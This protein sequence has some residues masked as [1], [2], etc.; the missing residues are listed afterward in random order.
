MLD[1]DMTI[2]EIKKELEG[3]GDFVQIDELTR[4]L[5]QKIKPDVRKFL[6]ERLAVIYEAKGM[7]VDAARMHNN[8]A[9]ASIAFAEKKIHHIAEAELYIDAGQFD[10]ADQAMKKAMSDASPSEKAEIFVTIKNYY[11][12]HAQIL[13]FKRRKNHAVKIYEKLLSMDISQVEKR[14][15][16]EKLMELYENLGMIREYMALKRE[17]LNN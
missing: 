6:H 16:K 2:L 15:I 4:L 8:V 12:R 9:L 5:K 3:K 11:K 1:K 14:E 13:E 17:N 10:M 7:F